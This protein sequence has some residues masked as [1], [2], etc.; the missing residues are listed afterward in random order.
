MRDQTNHKQKC[1]R[2]KWDPEEISVLQVSV[3][4]PAKLD[5]TWFNGKQF[6]V[7]IFH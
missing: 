1:L 2:I 3:A 5:K 6:G 7:I 4:L